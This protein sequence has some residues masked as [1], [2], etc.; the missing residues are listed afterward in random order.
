MLSCLIYGVLFAFDA[1]IIRIFNGDAALVQAAS[2]A[3]PL[4]ALSFIPMAVNLIA[5]AFLFSTKRTG[6]ANMIAMS[7]GVVVK[8]LAVFLVP[9]LLGANASWIAPLMVEVITLLFATALCRESGR[10]YFEKAC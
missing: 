1:P 4:F 8:A 3:L 9:G 6:A 7:R 2:A 10:V 5:T